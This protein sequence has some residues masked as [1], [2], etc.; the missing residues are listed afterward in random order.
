MCTYSSSYVGAWSFNSRVP[1]Q[2]FSRYLQVNPV[3]CNLNTATRNKS[4]VAHWIYKLRKLSSTI[5]VYMLH[6]THMKVYMYIRPCALDRH[7]LC[8]QCS[9]Q[10][11]LPRS[12]AKLRRLMLGK[13]VWHTDASHVLCACACKFAVCSMLATYNT[14]MRFACNAA[15]CLYVSLVCTATLLSYYILLAVV[16]ASMCYHYHPFKVPFMCLGFARAQA[17]EAFSFAKLSSPVWL[18]TLFR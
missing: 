14:H 5:A 16:H 3:G 1:K 17:S 4:I 13:R 8:K 7:R 10:V 2:R 12:S 18:Y 9:S 15:S 11:I 6:N